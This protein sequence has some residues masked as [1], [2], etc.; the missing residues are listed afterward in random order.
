MNSTFDIIKGIHPGLFL[1]RELKARKL[2]K[3]KFAMSVNE[4]PQT[5][6]SITKGKRNMNISLAL[7]IEAALDLEE[8][9]LMMLQVYHD[10]AEEKRKHSEKPDLTKFRRVLFWDTTID[11]ID[12][13]KQKRAVINRVFKRGNDQEK[14]ETIRFY[15]K[16]TVHALLKMHA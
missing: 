9:Y 6:G 5:L 11:K 12:W 14:A 16:D 15:G 7:K 1:D 13:Q 2:R 4:F 8:G 10:I 3:G